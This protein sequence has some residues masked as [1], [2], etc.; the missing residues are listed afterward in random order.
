M[1]R[2]RIVFWT[3]DGKP[4]PEKLKSGD[5]SYTWGE[6]QAQLDSPPLKAYSAEI[7]V[8]SDDFRG[9]VYAG[10]WVSK[11]NDTGAISGEL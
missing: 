5:T 8:Y 4:L 2:Y 3:E 9:W 11:Y 6:I 7:S 1:F 10:R